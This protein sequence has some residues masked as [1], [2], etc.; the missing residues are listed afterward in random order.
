MENIYSV[1]EIKN[2]LEPI[3]E[4]YGLLRASVFGSYAK[5]TADKNSDI[6][7]LIYIDESFDIEKYKGFKDEV[8]KTLSKEVDLLEYRCIKKNLKADILG[9]AID[10]YEKR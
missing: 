9:G 6:N 2:L 10:I 3:F 4:K 1:G 5:G 7:L 8:T